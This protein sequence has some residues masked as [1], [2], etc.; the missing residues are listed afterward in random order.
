MF[1]YSLFPFEVYFVEGENSMLMRPPCCL[2]VCII[3]VLGFE[4]GD[5]FCK[6]L[7]EHRAAGAD[8]SSVW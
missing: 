5:D 8:P 1:H 7:C 4:T 2:H 3:P 6:T